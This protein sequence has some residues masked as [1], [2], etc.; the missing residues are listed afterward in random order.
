[1]ELKGKKI[2][3][4]G[5]SITQGHG[6]SGGPGDPTNHFVT[7]VGQM[8]ECREVKNHGIGGTRFA[9]QKNAV[10]YHDFNDFCKRIEELDEDSDIVVVFGGTNDYGHGDALLGT[11]E[12]RDVYTFYGACHHVMTRMLE[13]FTGKPMLIITPVHRSYEGNIDSCSHKGDAPLCRF[14]EIIREV[15][16]YYSIPVLD[17]Y[18]ESG[19]QPQI[20]AVREK[21][22][23]DGLHPNDEGHKIMA[24]MIYKKLLSM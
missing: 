4:L 16:Q 9:K 2:S 1:M 5:D 8:G 18:A 10:D 19:I 22:C 11:F 17:F 7:L 6:T 13:R 15:A 3:F 23:P 24:N 21:L 20:E 14:V 12:D